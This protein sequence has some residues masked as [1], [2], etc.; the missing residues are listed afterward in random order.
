MLKID[1]IFKFFK[2][3]ELNQTERGYRS[4][5]TARA[6]KSLQLSVL[7]TDYFEMV[8]VFSNI[9]ITAFICFIFFNIKDVCMAL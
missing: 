7:I 2:S 8:L 9:I 6:A 1:G 4:K 5:N 3:I